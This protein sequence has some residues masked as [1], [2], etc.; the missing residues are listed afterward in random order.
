[1]R[2]KSEYPKI[3]IG[4]FGLPRSTHITFS[5]ILENII[6]P[7]EAIGNIEVRYH[8]YKQDIVYNPRSGENSFLSDSLYDPFRQFV[9]VEQ[10]PKGITEAM[11]FE[12]IKK[13]GDAYN[14]NFY[15]LRNLLL[16]LNSL[17]N[18]TSQIEELSPDLVVF[19]RPD[20]CYHNSFANVLSSAL[21][22][23]QP[24]VYLPFWQWS[25]GYNDRFAVCSKKSFK[26]YGQRGAYIQDYLDTY[27][28][29]PLHSERLLRYILDKHYISVRPINIRGTRVRA[30]GGGAD[31][32]FEEI[33]VSR[34]IRWAWKELQ[35]KVFNR[36]LA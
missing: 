35:K 31:E 6:K 18:L 34:K 5:S 12:G 25:G 3:C 23:V 28:D 7:A 20:I 26:V 19:A 8:L 2:M 1:M 30:N 15:S 32:S 27:P 29:K 4:F 33:K 10:D 21:L 9:G 24:R 13:S 11:N 17:I 22:D 36:F 14:D 16:Q